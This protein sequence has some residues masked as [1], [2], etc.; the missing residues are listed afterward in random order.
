ME[1][2]KDVDVSVNIQSIIKST[3]NNSMRMNTHIIT[4]SGFKLK[5]A[6]LSEKEIEIIMVNTKF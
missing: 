1:T 3:I 2:D 5:R 6:E 4:G